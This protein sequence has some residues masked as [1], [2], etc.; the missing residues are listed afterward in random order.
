MN[1][2]KKSL[3]ISI[4]FIICINAFFAGCALSNKKY[5]VAIRVTSDDGDVVT[6]TTD[7]N[8]IHIERVYDGLEHFYFVSAYQLPRHPKWGNKW[9][10]AEHSGANTFMSILT[11]IGEDGRRVEVV[12]RKI[13]ERGEYCY[14]FY[15]DSSSDIWNYRSVYLIIKVV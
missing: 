6:F 1:H 7:K 4:I 8:E 10:E 13:K 15:A 3:I 12:N 14:D 11:Y 2:I 5:D 9:F